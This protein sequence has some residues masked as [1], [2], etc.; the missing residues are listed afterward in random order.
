MIVGNVGTD[1]AQVVVTVM[2]G[3]EVEPVRREIPV[4]PG[5]V[6]RV[7]VAELTDAPEPGVMVETIGGRV[8]VDHR[9][10]RGED[11]A[12]GPCARRSL[13]EV[14]FAS[15]TTQKGAELWLA[16]FNPFPDDAIVDITALTET[17]ARSPAGLR[18]IV[19]PRR[20][21]VSVP[22]HEGLPRVDQVAVTVAGRRGRFI[23]EQSLTLDG[24]DGR[25]GYAVSLGT[26]P[27]RESWVPS[28]VIGS[29]RSERLVLANPSPRDVR[30]TVSFSLDAAAAIEPQPMLLPGSSVT[31][32]NLDRVPP[33]VPFS[34]R[35]RSRRPI[36]VE[37]IAAATDP[38]PSDARGL[39]SDMG[40]RRGRARWV[41]VPARVSATSRD[42]LAV[43]STDG[44]AHRAV[45]RGRDEAGRVVERVVEVPARRRAVVDLRELDP[46]GT[47]AL[48]LR[49]NGPV[50]V[51]RESSAPGITRSHAIAG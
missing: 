31:T 18:G 12:L 46:A 1:A 33:D 15:G 7:P 5:A 17:G 19:V 32:V 20:S 44:R 2:A 39:A 24:S 8:A 45:V 3:A 34:M 26:E 40:I 9:V 41:I 36:V 11:E 16:L 29:G 50:A 48:W 23:A 21:R 6:V 22:I 28:A 43:I 30:A 51:G 37:S 47:R 4:P 35:V 13:P 49:S 10:V 42:S 27:S 25:Q 38:Q 14:S